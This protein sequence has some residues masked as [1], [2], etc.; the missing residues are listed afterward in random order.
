MALFEVPGWSISSQP[1][2]TQHP[3]R[4]RKRAGSQDLQLRSAQVNLDKLIN[5]LGDRATHHDGDAPKKKN[6][7]PNQRTSQPSDHQAG[8]NPRALKKH[9]KAKHSVASAVQTS[10]SNTGASP[11]KNAKKKKPKAESAPQP[12]LFEENSRLPTTARGNTGL[13][14]LQRNMKESLDGARFRSVSQSREICY[15]TCPIIKVDK[16]SV[17]QVK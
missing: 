11:K 4:K 3:S 9:G 17:V 15:L 13:T 5:T 16:R 1:I 10:T 2:S 8:E 6:K 7:K 12:T 14:A